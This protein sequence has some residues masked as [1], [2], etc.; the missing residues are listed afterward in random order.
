MARV[1]I[2]DPEPDLALLAAEAVTELGHE[3]VVLEEPPSRTDADVLMIASCED[4]RRI[5][6]RLREDSGGLSVIVVSV[7]APDEEARALR[8][9]GFLA[10][11][12]T[13]EALDRAMGRALDAARSGVAD[14]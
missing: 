3:A 5:V 4:M 9:A 7:G 6:D 8:G 14:D 10:K 1:L 12:Y 13:L 2:L 11:P